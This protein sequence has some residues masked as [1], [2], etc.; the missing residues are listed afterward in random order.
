MRRSILLVAF[1][2]TVF[3]LMVLAQQNVATTSTLSDTQ[4]EGRR[5]FQQKC[6]VCHVPNSPRAKQYAPGLF[7]GVVDGTGD[8]MPGF[9]YALQPEQ[10]N[11]IIEYLQTLDQPPRTVASERDEM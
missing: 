4:R 6:A 5:I 10:L 7:K 8:R 11:E 2:F 3:P 1:L 9:K